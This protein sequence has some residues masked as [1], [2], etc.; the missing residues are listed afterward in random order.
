M[1]RENLTNAFVVALLL[2]VGA[3]SWRLQLRESLEVDTS[4]LVALPYQIADWRGRDIPVE[5]EVSEMLDATL[6]VQRAYTAPAGGLVWLYVGYYGTERGGRP[7]HT[8][9]VC[10]PTAGWEIVRAEEI[11][12][13]GQPDHPVNELLVEQ[14]GERRLVHFYYRSMRRTGLLGGTDQLL[15]HLVSRLLTGR[16]DGALVRLSTIV[17]GDEFVARARLE[18]L[19]RHVDGLFQHHWPRE[20]SAQIGS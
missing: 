14:R 8:P 4:A 1:A 11:R 6:N 10:Y 20:G 2:A 16:A 19:G 7:E 13:R 15:D 18:D 5:D 3:L 9:W 17:D 12:V